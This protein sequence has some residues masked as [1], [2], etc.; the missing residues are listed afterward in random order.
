MYL[1]CKACRN[2]LCVT[3]VSILVKKVQSIQVHSQDAWG[4][5]GGRAQTLDVEERGAKH[6]EGTDQ[7]CH[8]M[9]KW[10]NHPY[11]H[12]ELCKIIL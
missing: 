10:L 9:Y 6:G 8:K 3:Y 12:I 5:N 4:T 2:C 1:D 11:K 7:T